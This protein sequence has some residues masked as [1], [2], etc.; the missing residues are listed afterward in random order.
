M[1]STELES[2]ACQLE[3]LTRIKETWNVG[4]PDRSSSCF[5]LSLMD[6]ILPELHCKE[7]LTNHLEAFPSSIARDYIVF[8]S[9][10]YSDKDEQIREIAQKLRGMAG[11]DDQHRARNAQRRAA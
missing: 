3:G 5:T 7:W 4:P 10:F 1:S 8:K 2:L 9:E 6:S 11:G